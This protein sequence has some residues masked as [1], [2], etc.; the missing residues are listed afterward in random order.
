MEMEQEEYKSRGIKRGRD[1]VDDLNDAMRNMDI[2]QKKTISQITIERPN[3]EQLAAK[4]DAYFSSAFGKG[5]VKRR[6]TKR[7]QNKRKNRRTKRR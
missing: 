6:K 2:N 7:S 5:G 3:R 1:N 4:R